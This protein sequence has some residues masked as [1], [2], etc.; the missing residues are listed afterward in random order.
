MS[1]ELNTSELAEIAVDDHRDRR[2]R[3]LVANRAFGALKA[4]HNAERGLVEAAADS[5]NEIAASTPF[6]LLHLIWFLIWIP[7]NLGWL[8]FQAE[9]ISQYPNEDEETRR[10]KA[11]VLRDPIFHVAYPT[12]LEG[13]EG[14]AGPKAEP[15]AGH[16][17]IP[18]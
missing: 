13:L 8:G 18:R 10:L 4:Q 12:P 15:V 14:L 11:W 3:R 6:L 7:W 16:R 17:R 5:L 2:R 1:G 9:F